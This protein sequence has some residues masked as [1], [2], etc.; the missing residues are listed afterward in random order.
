MPPEAVVEIGAFDGSGVNLSFILLK[1]DMVGE[2][3]AKDTFGF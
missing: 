3:M 2:S 1:N